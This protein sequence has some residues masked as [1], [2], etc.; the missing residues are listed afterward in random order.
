MLGL[1]RILS[2]SFFVFVFV[3]V[4]EL[5]VGVIGR[6]ISAYIHKHRVL[7]PVYVPIFLRTFLSLFLYLSLYLYLSLSL[8][9]SSLYDRGYSPLYGNISYEG[10]GMI[11]G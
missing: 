4:L 8:Y 1:F 11:L 6:D 9:L 3:F 2:L 5:S 10:F 7:K